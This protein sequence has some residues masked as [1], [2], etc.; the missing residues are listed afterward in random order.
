MGTREDI[1]KAANQAYVERGYHGF[2]MRHVA[3]EVGIT[4]MAIYRHF[5]D[6]DDLLHH[7]ALFG[8]A[9]WRQQLLAQG[10]I[11]DPWERIFGVGC[12]YARF[13]VDHPAH[14]EVV[15][16]PTDRLAELRHL[17]EDGS[18]QFD[19]VFSLFAR[20]V[21]EARGHVEVTPKVRECAIDIWGYS[22][23]LVTLELAGRLQFLDVD[24]SVYY[25]RKLREFL[26]WKQTEVW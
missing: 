2:S 22:H 21:G 13:A 18:R 12:A 7:M 26:E 23:G 25:A 17:T 1:L 10:E 15:F 8:L 6:K 4:P 3:A 16:L 19:E 9:A 14:F 5:K 24:F 20:W 11:L